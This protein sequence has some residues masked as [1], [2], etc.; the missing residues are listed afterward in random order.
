M[1]RT[2]ARVWSIS[3]LLLAALCRVCSLPCDRPHLFSPVQLRAGGNAASRRVVLLRLCGGRLKG[4]CSH[5]KEQPNLQ[6]MSSNE[7]MAGE[8]WH[9]DGE[10]QLPSAS[11]SDDSLDDGD[12]IFRDP[13]TQRE[14]EQF[15]DHGVHPA[16]TGVVGRLQ[17]CRGRACAD[18]AID[19]MSQKEATATEDRASKTMETDLECH[20][21]T[22]G[23]PSPSHTQ[24]RLPQKRGTLVPPRVL[25]P[26]R[27]TDLG[28]N[29]TGPAK[30][31]EWSSW[32]A[33]AQ[34]AAKDPP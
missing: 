30:R 14:W 9:Q 8:A 33:A 34:S 23:P 17:G 27:S 18:P 15:A 25:T 2:T 20:P 21:I 7:S 4:P 26:L 1:D 24:P 19:A 28:M 31:Q 29:D 13:D 16:P 22:G 12:I 10:A 32:L 5:H 6:Q 3:P 11:I